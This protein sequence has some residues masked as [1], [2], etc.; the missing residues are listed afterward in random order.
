MSHESWHKWGLIENTSYKAYERDWS[1]KAFN[2]LGLRICKTLRSLMW[3][4]CVLRFCAVQN[5]FKVSTSNVSCEQGIY[6]VLSF[7]GVFQRNVLFFYRRT[8]KNHITNAVLSIVIYSGTNV[9]H[10]YDVTN[11]SEA[12]KNLINYGNVLQKT[13]KSIC[14]EWG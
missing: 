1:G 12:V 13:F 9:V 3:L 5:W 2:S 11:T 6:I 10:R 7:S 14:N 4:T 8:Y